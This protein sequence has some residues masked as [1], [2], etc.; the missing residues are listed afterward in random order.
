MKRER[1]LMR[2]EDGEVGSNGIGEASP[3]VID[4][5]MPIKA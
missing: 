2:R 3:L 5:P 1:L 4:I